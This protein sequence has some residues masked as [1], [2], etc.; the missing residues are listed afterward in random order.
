MVFSGTS[1]TI[2]SWKDKSGNGSNATATGS[3][4][5]NQNSINGVQSVETGSGKY[6]N[7]NISNVRVY[8]NKALSAAEV[9]QTFN[10]SKSRFGL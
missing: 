3:P 8:K 10:A 7:G 5:L 9:L 6:F 1:T 4:T 2:T